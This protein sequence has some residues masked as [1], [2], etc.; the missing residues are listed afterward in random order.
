M[1]ILKNKHLFYENR[2]G[3]V[4]SLHFKKRGSKK[5]KAVPSRRSGVLTPSDFQRKAI[6][7]MCENVMNEGVDKMYKG[8]I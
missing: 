6:Y 3:E 2:C 4:K 5:Y 8:G 1:S 7:W